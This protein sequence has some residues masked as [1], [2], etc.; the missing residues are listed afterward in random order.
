MTGTQSIPFVCE[1]CQVRFDV[2]NGG[3][4]RACHRLLCSRHFA[5]LERW[6]F[7]RRSEV[8]LVQPLCRACSAAGLDPEQAR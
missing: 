2:L 7:W 6:P 4:C 5:F 3:I 8:R 1:E